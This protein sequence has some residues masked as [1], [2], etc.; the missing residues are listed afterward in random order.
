M[1]HRTTAPTASNSAVIE[2]GDGVGLDVGFDGCVIVW[3]WLRAD[4]GRV[5]SVDEGL[6]WSTGSSCEWLFTAVKNADDGDRISE[7]EELNGL[8]SL[9]GVTCKLF[10]N[11]QTALIT[12]SLRSAL[13]S[14]SAHRITQSFKRCSSNLHWVCN[15]W[16]CS[17]VHWSTFNGSG[18]TVPV[19]TCNCRIIW[20]SWTACCD[21]IASAD[22]TDWLVD[23]S[24]NWVDE[25]AG[26]GN[27][28]IQ[29]PCESCWS[30]CR[31]LGCWPLEFLI[32]ELNQA[33]TLLMDS[34]AMV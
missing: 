27:G 4:V 10:E 17:R 28:A 9:T 11:V 13:C 31:R 34:D 26:G 6:D 14:A 7:G 12:P 23:W 8:L 21:A 2:E 22:K 30:E 16:M 33:I 3:D 25:D 5:G 1:E 20:L 29:W 24:L 18:R 19:M 15:N 32:L